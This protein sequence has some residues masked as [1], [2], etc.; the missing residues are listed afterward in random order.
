VGRGPWAA[1]SRGNWSTAPSSQRWQAAA[2]TASADLLVHQVG[3]GPL[4]RICA[5]QFACYDILDGGVTTSLALDTHGKSLS[6]RL[7]ALKLNPAVTPCAL[8]AHVGVLHADETPPA[9]TKSW[10]VSI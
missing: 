2:S 5:P 3:K 7:L 4:P 1:W 8:L 6:S 10:V 9:P